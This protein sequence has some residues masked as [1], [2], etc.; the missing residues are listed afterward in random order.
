MT[1]V[2]WLI[3]LPPGVGCDIMEYESEPL[4][5]YPKLRNCSYYV[6]LTPHPSRLLLSFT[7]HVLIPPSYQPDHPWHPLRLHEKCIYEVSGH[8][9]HYG[10]LPPLGVHP[11]GVDPCGFHR[12]LYRWVIPLSA[13]PTFRR[14]PRDPSRRLMAEPC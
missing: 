12:L 7:Y 3:I 4:P 5:S 6:Q 14:H 2:S 8:F 13:C 1:E 11:D 9:I 10:C